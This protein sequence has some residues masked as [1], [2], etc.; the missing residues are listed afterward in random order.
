MARVPASERTRNALKDMFAGKTAADKS[1]LVRQ[2]A[3]LIVEEALEKEAAAALG[4]GYYEHGADR[5]GYRNGYRLGRVKSAEGEIE[6]A[7]SQLTDI[8]EPFR[9]KIREV[10]RERTEELERLA[11]FTP[12]HPQ[13][14]ECCGRLP[15]PAFLP[16]GSNFCRSRSGAIP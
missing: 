12:P 9:P 14:C 7:L 2:A 11:A 10:L 13:I 3:R 4:S 1:S 8:A 5:R 15:M 6:F 16:R